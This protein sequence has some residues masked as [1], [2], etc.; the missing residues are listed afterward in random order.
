MIIAR[1]QLVERVVNY[2]PEPAEIRCTATVPDRSD[3]LFTG[4]FP[5]MPLFPGN[6]MLEFMAQSCGMLLY[7]HTDGRK[8]SLLAGIDRAR[9][10]APVPPGSA[11]VCRGSLTYE[12]AL[13]AACTAKLMHG[14][15]VAANAEIRLSLTLPP[16]T[17][18]AGHMRRQAEATGLFTADRESAPAP[19]PRHG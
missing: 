18:V 13:A 9:F 4:H 1:F 11:L 15:T 19:E 14:D 5:G 10:R 7:R 6:L 12:N 17:E 8:I 2:C 16:N 3:E